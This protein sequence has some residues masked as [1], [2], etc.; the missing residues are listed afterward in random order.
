MSP[1][2]IRFAR[3]DEGPA[4][5]AL[6]LRSKAH[7]GYDAAFLRRCV[8]VL[9]VTPALLAGGGVLVAEAGGRVQ[10]L[11]AATAEDAADSWD[12]ALC[13][14]EPAAMGQGVGRALFAAK[15]RWLRDRGARRL[16]ILSDPGAEPFY[17]RMGA[18]GLRLAPSDAIAGRLLP[19]LELRL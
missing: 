3:A 11:I 10:G 1:L 5:T 4:L 7:W 14:V 17:R 12:L 15:L 18:Q 19:L 8:P 9:T 16:T 13:F 6:C 2:T